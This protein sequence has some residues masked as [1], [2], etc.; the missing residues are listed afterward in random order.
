MFDNMSDEQL[1][2]VLK[3]YQDKFAQTEASGKSP[4]AT[5][6]GQAMN[7]RWVLGEAIRRGLVDVAGKRR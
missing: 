5:D 4:E 3:K 7:A 2:E 1:L 6:P